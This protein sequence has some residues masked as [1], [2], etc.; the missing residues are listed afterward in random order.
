MCQCAKESRRLDMAGPLL[1]RHHT[2]IPNRAFR[3]KPLIQ[4]SGDS[5]ERLVDVELY[6]RLVNDDQPLEEQIIMLFQT[7]EKTQLLRGLR[8]NGV[9]DSRQGTPFSTLVLHKFWFEWRRASLEFLEN[10]SEC[11]VFVADPNVQVLRVSLPIGCPAL[12]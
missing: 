6:R 2:T 11:R 8:R 4:A 9:A 5:D 10:L 12:P 3:N 1:G 7:L